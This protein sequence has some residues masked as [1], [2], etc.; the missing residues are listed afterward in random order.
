MIEINGLNERIANLKMQYQEAERINLKNKADELLVDINYLEELRELR[1]KQEQKQKM[2][3]ELSKDYNKLA[4]AYAY[5][6]NYLEY[7][8]DV[9]KVWGTVTLNTANL[10]KAYAKG[11]RDENERWNTSMD[12][13]IDNIKNKKAR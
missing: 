8:V 11:R 3:D 10:E 5:A 12:R 1:N 4:I 13:F 7:G 2:L 6:K 9:T